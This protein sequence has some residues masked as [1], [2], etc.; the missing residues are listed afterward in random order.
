M[1][2]KDR[3]LLM[4]GC[5]PSAINPH[6]HRRTVSTIVSIGTISAIG[7]V[8]D[9]LWDHHIKEQTILTRTRGRSGCRRIGSRRLELCRSSRVVE[10]LAGSEGDEKLF[11]DVDPIR[12]SSWTRNARVACLDSRVPAGGSYWGGEA[13]IP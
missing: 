13:Q 11:S 1:Y 2:R 7:T 9:G 8:K 10:R 5:L 4:E 3:N 6:K 12:I